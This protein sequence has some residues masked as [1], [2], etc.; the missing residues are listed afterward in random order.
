MMRATR[1]RWLA[2]MTL[3][4]AAATLPL[5]AQA[6]DWRLVG[7]SGAI[8]M[9]FD[10]ESLV[11]NSA[12][13]SLTYRMRAVGDLRA[14]VVAAHPELKD[15]LDGFDVHEIHSDMQFSCRTG[16]LD[17]VYLVK[18]LDSKGER[19]LMTN[20]FVRNFV[21]SARVSARNAST[22]EARDSVIDLCRDLRPR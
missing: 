14:M 21:R 4:L 8:E 6:Q 16:E 11:Y 20:E 19:L 5:A 2:G 7:G 10:A 13:D 18:V 9:F 1:T 17:A 22:A 3:A 12:G 15:Q